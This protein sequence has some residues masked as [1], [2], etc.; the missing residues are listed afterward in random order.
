MKLF[1]IIILSLFLNQG[2]EAQATKLPAEMPEKITVYLNESGGMRRAYK[3]ITI[4]DGVLEFVEL[5][6]GQQNPQTWS[7]SVAREDLIKLYKTFV[8]NKFDTIKN[9]ER[10]GIVYD[11]GSESISISVNK[12]KSYGVTYGKNSPLS[13]NNL[14]KYQAVRR[15]LDELVAKYRSEDRSMNEAENRIQ[16]TWRAEGE[17]GGR[18]WFLEWTFAGGKFKQTGYPPITQEGK[19]RVLSSDA[20]QLTLELYEQEGTFG[21]GKREIR[22]LPDKETGQLTISGRS[23]FKRTAGK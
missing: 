16:G 19:Y 8:E 17:S 13:G 6:G 7:A 10:Q 11:A 5:K 15:A 21:G 18:S 22:I 23:G 1:V 14:Q 4:D 3:K 2:C 20:D 12:L 9:D